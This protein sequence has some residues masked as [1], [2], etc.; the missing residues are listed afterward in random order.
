[1]SAV[2]TFVRVIPA[3]IFALSLLGCAD[4]PEPI[5]PGESITLEATGGWTKAEVETLQSA[6]TEWRSFTDGKLDCVVVPDGTAADAKL[7]RGPSGARTG[8]YARLYPLDREIRIDADALAT[9]G[10]TMEQ[11][12]GAVTRN[13]IGLAARIPEHD[14]DGV[15]G[16][17]SMAP[18]LT[19]ADRVVCRSAGFCR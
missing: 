11:G 15:M 17:S 16:T 13:A 1:M 4:I 3:A 5:Q 18:H 19:E 6:C 14:S 8:G 9:D 12:L 10:F 2:S 7:V